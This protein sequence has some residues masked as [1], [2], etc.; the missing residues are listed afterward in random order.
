MCG[1]VGWGAHADVLS[2]CWAAFLHPLSPLAGC[3]PCLGT[4]VDVD[5]LG[6]LRGQVGPSSN[7]AA[8]VG[9]EL[10][11]EGHQLRPQQRLWVPC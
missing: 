8:E 5:G 2:S 1:P 6:E 10:A 7:P 11:R 9:R 4:V 3:A